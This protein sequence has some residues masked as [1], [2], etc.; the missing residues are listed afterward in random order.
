[1]FPAF[2]VF[3]TLGVN[4]TIQ[5]CYPEISNYYIEPRQCF[6]DEYDCL[7][8]RV[9]DKPPDDFETYFLEEFGCR[10]LLVGYL[11]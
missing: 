10:S 1:M 11:F 5:D 4:P 3:C 2:L 7:R 6:F 9:Y 8:V